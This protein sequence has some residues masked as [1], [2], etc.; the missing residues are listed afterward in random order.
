MPTDLSERRP[1]AVISNAVKVM[2]IATAPAMAA[3]LSKVVMTWGDFVAL[4]DSDT[5]KA[6]PRGPLQ[7]S[8]SLTQFPGTHWEHC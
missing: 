3:G 1:A 8:R 7:K 4:T 5:P 6:G 2:R